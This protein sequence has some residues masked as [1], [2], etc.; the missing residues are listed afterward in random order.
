MLRQAADDVALNEEELLEHLPDQMILFLNPHDVSYTLADLD[1]LARRIPI[2][3][4]HN[5]EII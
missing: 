4:R 5:G 3:I 2:R 1:D